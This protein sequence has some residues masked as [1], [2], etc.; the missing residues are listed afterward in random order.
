[1]KI[2]AGMACVNQPNFSSLTLLRWLHWHQQKRTPNREYCVKC[3]TCNNTTKNISYHK[4]NNIHNT[5]NSKFNTNL[6]RVQTGNRILD[7]D[8]WKSSIQSFCLY[9]I[10]SIF[11]FVSPSISA[12][13]TYQSHTL[14]ISLL[15][16]ISLCVP[17][18]THRVY[19]ILS[20]IN[21]TSVLY[22]ILCGRFLLLFFFCC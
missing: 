14:F 22:F 8:D 3:V 2:I 21:P 7:L 19:N 6:S 11:L 16:Y 12:F 18:P 9:I 13:I 4:T 15:L 20:Y 17:P 1:M 5:N 10:C